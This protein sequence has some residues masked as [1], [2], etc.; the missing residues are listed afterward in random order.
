MK[1]SEIRR[2]YIEFFVEKNHKQEPSM[3]LVPINDNSL[4][5]INSGV[6]TLKKYFD[7]SVIPDNPRITNA[8]KARGADL[9]NGKFKERLKALIPILIPLLI[10]SVRR[11][12]EL[13]EAMEC[14]CYNGG[15]GR[16]RMKRLKYSFSD[17]IAL[18]FS[19][20]SCAAVIII[21]IKV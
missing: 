11:A 12:Y 18:V 7:G 13:A 21:N 15:V 5:W 17:L 14:R 16:V 8:Q 4:L 1:A 2:K 6:A 3:P 20:V 9:E 19:L 10:S